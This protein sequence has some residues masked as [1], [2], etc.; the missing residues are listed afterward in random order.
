MSKLE[1]RIGYTGGLL[2]N[3]PSS[4]TII[5]Q[6]GSTSGTIT[7]ANPG[8][9]QWYNANISTSGTTYGYTDP[10]IEYESLAPISINHR[11][12]YKRLIVWEP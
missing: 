5:T 9:L 10:T 12:S 3:S 1:K 11:Y 4:G 7:V 6:S 2:T 8:A